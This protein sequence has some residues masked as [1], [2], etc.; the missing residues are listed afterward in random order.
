L[1][2]GS[3]LQAPCDEESNDAIQE[4][5]GY[6]DCEP[7]ETHPDIE[8][9]LA[10]KL[11]EGATT[12]VLTP[13]PPELPCAPKLPQGRFLKSNS[14]RESKDYL[15]WLSKAIEGRKTEL[16]L[17]APDLQQMTIEW[18][19]CAARSVQEICE[20]DSWVH[21]EV[22]RVAG[23]LTCYS[24]WYWPGS[25]KSL[26]MAASP[27]IVVREGRGKEEKPR[28]WFEAAELT[29]SRLR[30]AL[31]ELSE[32]RLDEDGWCDESALEPRP[33]SWRSLFNDVVSRL[34]EMTGELGEA[35][36]PALLDNG[37]NFGKREIASMVELAKKSRWLR[38]SVDG[39]NELWGHLMGRFRHLTYLGDRE[40]DTLAAVI[41]P[42]YSPPLSWARLLKIDPNK[43]VRQRERKR[44]YR[45]LGKSQ[46]SNPETLSAWLLEAFSAFSNP[47]VL[48]ILDGAQRALISDVE[49]SGLPSKS[50]RS[51]MRRLLK[52]LETE[53]E[54]D[55]TSK[56]R[57]IKAELNLPDNEEEG[58]S[59]EADEYLLVLEEVR[60]FV[61]G[62]KVLIV[63]NRNDAQLREQLENEIE[64][65]GIDVTSDS[66]RRIQSVC[67]S[68]RQSSY[69]LVL[70]VT[71]FLSHS[72]DGALSTASSDANI[73]YVRTNKG[74]PRNTVIA[75][76]RALGFGPSLS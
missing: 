45:E 5:P 76:G 40:Y 31:E 47:E 44:L 57:V 72:T 32:R 63:T 41:A 18:W 4:V 28:T 38:L 11:E 30:R 62:K 19:I 55:G 23:V 67:Q 69:A 7:Q 26:Q 29:E 35:Y 3:G 64:P 24:K 68:I 70:A 46:I 17:L 75:V 56:S 1:D 43:K 13:I 34:E 74:R 51:R 14:R 52:L 12:E 6:S 60:R 66:P 61:K 37:G 65:R 15:E 50:S 8:R 49:V 48:T 25:I 2:V 27:D 71:G 39:G 20:G 54:L 16:G 10:G 59:G 21:S 33:A 22:Q 42:G 36:N 58:A 73:C 9:T 53:K